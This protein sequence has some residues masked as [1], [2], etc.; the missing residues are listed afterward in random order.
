MSAHAKVDRLD[1][2][3]KPWGAYCDEDG[4]PDRFFDEDFDT[5]AEA[6]AAAL[7]H[8]RDYPRKDQP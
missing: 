6:L 3:E 2:Y 1:G 5:H 7:Q 8:C 4:C